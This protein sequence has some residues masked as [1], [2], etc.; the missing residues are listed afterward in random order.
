M[1]AEVNPEERN[2]VVS[3]RA[4]L[5]KEREEVREKVWAELAEGQIREGIVRSV[6]DFGAFVDIGGLDGLLPISQLSWSRVEKVTDVVTEGQKVKVVVL[7]LDK[8]AR[9]VSLGLKQLAAS[10]WDNIQDKYAAG[11]VVTGKV[12]R[13]AEFGAFVE[14]EPAVEGLIHISELAPQRVFRAKD[15]VQV[16][17]DVKVLVLAVD[18][19]QR[20]I[21]LSLKQAVAKEAPPEE[22]EE[23]EDYTPP[24]PRPYNPNLRGGVGGRP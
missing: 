18:P 13:L 5:E 10:P 6:R 7:K 17:Q 14:L 22:V 24:P 2:L 15:I 23:D 20:R 21:S 16:G 12:S 8:V 9:K 1:I 3:R 11:S 4:L 19:A